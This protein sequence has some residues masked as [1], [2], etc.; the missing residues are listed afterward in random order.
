M[1]ANGIRPDTFKAIRGLDNP[2]NFIGSTDNPEVYNLDDKI[3]RSL[4]DLLA[5]KGFPNE[6]D[7]NILLRQYFAC[8]IAEFI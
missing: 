2:E 5:E 3:L 4:T 1:K 7:K 6:Y 8:K